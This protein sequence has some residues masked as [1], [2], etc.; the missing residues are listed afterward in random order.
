MTFKQLAPMTKINLA[1]V[2]ASF[3]WLQVL[4]GTL[5]VYTPRKHFIYENI[6]LN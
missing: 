6:G 2:A 1:T 3:E 4:Y 5:I